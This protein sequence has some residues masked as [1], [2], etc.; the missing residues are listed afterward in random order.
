MSSE[1][2]VLSEKLGL[3]RELIDARLKSYCQ[4]AYLGDG[5]PKKLAEALEYVL[6]APGKRLRPILVLLAAEACGG[7]PNQALPAAC[8]VEMIH[9]YSLVHDDLP[10][11]DN[12]DLRRGR[13]TCHIVFGEANAIL[14]G[15]ALI[16]LAFQLLSSEIEDPQKVLLCCAELAR[17][18]GAAALVGG[19][20][21]DLAGEW[22]DRSIATLEKIHRRK[23]GAMLNVSLRLG[24]IL[25]GATAT[26]LAALKNYGDA[27]GLAFQ[28]VDDLLDL[29]GTE[30]S[31]GKK[32]H[33]DAELG[34]LTFPG[35]LGI[36]ESRRRAANLI[37]QAIDACDVFSERGRY[38]R[39]V[40][41]YV[42]ERKN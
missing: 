1:A 36:E 31:L 22:E 27:I 7:D 10:A 25:G 17:A 37:Q 28:I 3:H 11:M 29:E 24:G 42:L 8:A 26:Q 21:D 35:L 4:L 6:L 30:Q 34:K 5:C 12:D 15:D 9:T 18:A 33:K 32:T 40:A 14:T 2:V 38:L 23:T 19:Q 41:Q 13:P 16:P 39:E 20:F